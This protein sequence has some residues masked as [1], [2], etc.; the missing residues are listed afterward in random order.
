[1][2][3]S[4]ASITNN[5]FLSEFHSIYFKLKCIVV[6]YG[7]N[8]RNVLFETYSTFVFLMIIC[9]NVGNI[10]YKALYTF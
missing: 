8:I 6:D 5:S 1:M 3:K 4:R 10:G 7:N 9:Y 2:S